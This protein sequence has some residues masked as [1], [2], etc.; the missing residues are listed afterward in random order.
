MGG[1]QFHRIAPGAG[2]VDTCAQTLLAAAR[3]RD[4]TAWRVVVP[5]LMIA[6]ALKQAL[7]RMAGGALLLPPVE[8]LQ[9]H[10][11]PWADAFAPMAEHRRRFAL[12]RQLR[13]KR[14]F[15]QGNLWALCA[16]FIALFDEL[17]E[18]GA[19]LPQ[20]AQALADQLA[21]A[22]AARDDDALRFE[23]RVVHALWLAES[24]GAPSLVAAR[25]L[26]AARWTASAPAPLLVIAEGP[27]AAPWQAWLEA[28]AE[29]APVM[30]CQADRSGADDPVLQCLEATW[31]T[32][33]ARSML[34]LKS[35][36]SDLSVDTPLVGRIAMRSADSL[37]QEAHAVVN[38]VHRALV[39]GAQSVALVAVD[40]VVAR[41][42]RALLERDGI[43]VADESGWKLST[44]RAAALVDA[45]FKVFH[46]DG[47]H[48][49]VLDLAKSPFVLSDLDDAVREE[50]VLALEQAI[51][52]HNHVL[53]LDA[54]AALQANHPP[55]APLLER[56]LAARAAFSTQPGTPRH[57][58]QRIAAMLDA[59]GATSALAQDAAGQVL[60]DWLEARALELQGEA[61]ELD[62]DEWRAWFEN[63]L[64]EALF[65][66]RSIRSPVILTHLPA[67]R[68]RGFDVAIVVG[69][70]DAQL[71]ADDARPIFAHEG[72]RLDL[73][74]PGRPSGIRR[75]RD[76]LAGLIAGCGRVVFTWQ[77]LR[78]GEPNA[79]AA[80]LDLLDLAHRMHFGTALVAPAAPVPMPARA[81]LGTPVP[82]PT[83]PADLRPARI[84][85]YGY[86]ALVR[87]PYQYFVRFVL[88]LDGVE[89]V[90]E[91]MEKR[92]YGQFVH[93]VLD[94]FHQQYPVVTG[95]DD[96]RMLA[97]LET[98]SQEAFEAAGRRGFLERAWLLRWCERLPDYL[99]WQ[100][101]REAEGWRYAV[102]EHAVTR[103]LPLDDGGPLTLSGRLDRVDRQGGQMAV[104]DYK[105][106]D[107]DRLRK[108]ANDPED[109]QLAVYAA[110][111]GESVTQAA[112]VSLDGDRLGAAAVADPAAHA[113]AHLA[114]LSGLFERLGQGAGMVANGVGSACDWCEVRGVCRKDHHA[115]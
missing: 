24:V 105:T 67:C 15:A 3:S 95:E 51:G 63:G 53:G 57:W 50:A 52:A 87:C 113:T 73:G 66:D 18:H 107:L 86:E 29:R 92:D 9:V 115:R 13:D 20:D 37:E 96:A 5:N 36:L 7:V 104:L 14:W 101:G 76:D 103:P 58:L 110:L 30:L 60:L 26:G 80:D 94:R 25:L 102:G 64:D 48:R 4:L 16:E 17:T 111:M 85:A 98:L 81:P 22:Y 11:A 28:H 75:L 88:G 35:R 46:H 34:P 82:A 10:L 55:M 27:L 74:L 44:T 49:D 79:L 69:A 70:D 109:V 23:A 108:Q 56:L 71:Q 89:T 77:R 83:M 62:F 97:V 61:C 106:R 42:A 100:R 21:R 1:V 31:P 78:E 114:R 8:T 72:V 33:P 47:Y 39:A 38:E 12:Y 84:T 68:L 6:P 45:C 19:G 65:R 43:L 2:F 41:R 90:Q 93:V 40:R 112:Y 59:L 99:A 54:L 32:D 91:A